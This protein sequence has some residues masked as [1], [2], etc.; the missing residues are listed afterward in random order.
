MPDETPESTDLT[1]AGLAFFGAVTASVTHELNNVISIIDQTIGLLD[2]AL[3]VAEE[4]MPVRPETLARVSQG[5]KRQTVRGVEQIK[6]L[7]AFAHSADHLRCE[8]DINA[9]M[10][11]LAGL[12]QRLA[13][14]R[15]LSLEF[16][17]SPEPLLITTNPFTA[18]QLVFLCLSEA[19]DQAEKGGQIK[20]TCSKN[21]AGGEINVEIAP[22]KLVLKKHKELSERLAMA[23]NETLGVQESDSGLTVTIQHQH[24]HHHQHQHFKHS[25]GSHEYASFISR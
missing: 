7:N 13:G 15:K 4:G 25:R 8:V 17:P 9:L 1:Q 5:I 10:S 3:A 12:Y 18:Q 19:C 2:D 6:R 21:L 16:V 11:N 20:V 24:Q 22:V 23:F 14:L